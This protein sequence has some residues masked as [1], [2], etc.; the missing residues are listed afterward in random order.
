[1]GGIARDAGLNVEQF[2]NSSDC[3]A[4]EQLVGREAR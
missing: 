4:N 3:N 2:K 1:M